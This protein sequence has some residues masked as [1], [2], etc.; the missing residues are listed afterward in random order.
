MALKL[1]NNA[2]TLLASSI[3]AVTTAITITSGDEGRF[4]SLGEDEWFPVTVVDAAGNMEIMRCTARSGVMLT[5]QRAQ[6]GTTAK[7]FIAGA[8]LDVRMTAAAVL[9]MLDRANHTGTQPLASISG[10]GSAAGAAVEDFATAAQGV[11]ASNAMPKSGGVFAGNVQIRTNDWTALEL[12]AWNAAASATLTM[13]RGRG[14]QAVPQ[15]VQSNDI[16]GGVTCWGYGPSAFVQAG[17]LQFLAATNFSAASNTL[18]RLGLLRDGT[19]FTAQTW[20][21]SGGSVL[22][23][24]TGGDPGNGKFNAVDYQIAGVSVAATLASLA[25]SLAA[26]ADTSYVDGLAIGVNQT[27]QT[28]SRSKDTSYQNTTGKPVMCYIAAS[29]AGGSGCYVSPD[30]STWTEVGQ[31]SGSTHLP[32]TFIVPDGYYYRFSGGSATVMSWKELR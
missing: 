3:D 16:L 6:E 7:S 24:P 19:Y 18:A 4:P 29:Q 32:N 23:A 17:W 5:V 8:R 28:P 9:A 22:G 2:S 13:R 1:A 26:K 21:S 20:Y 14:T 11:L 27:W 10:A 25:G 12:S 31:S 30:N 15:P